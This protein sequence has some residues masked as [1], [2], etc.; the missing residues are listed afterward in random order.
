MDRQQLE[1]FDAAFAE[2]TALL[3][4]DAVMRRSAA[5]VADGAALDVVWIAEP[6]DADRLVVRHL[7][8]TRTAVLEGLVVPRGWGLGGKVFAHG[9]VEAVDRYF[10]SRRITHHFDEQVASEGIE[11]MIAAPIVADG[12]TLAVLWG[13]RRRAGSI[14]SRTGVV[15]E[16]AMRGAAT[17]LVAAE[18]AERLAETAVHEHR[19]ALALGLHDSVG[20]MLFAIQAGIHDLSRGLGPDPALRGQ[21]ERIE[22]YAAEAA[23]ALRDSL[24]ALSVP[25]RQLALSVALRAD[26]RAFEQRSGIPV[27]FVVLATE[28]PAL[29][30]TRTE[31]L[32][33]AARE[34][35]LNVEK[36]A[37]ASSV[38]LALSTGHGRVQVT[39]TDDGA[40]R[41]PPGPAAR[42]G[43][44]LGATSDRLARLGGGLRLESPE[45]GGTIFRAWLP[46]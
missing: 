14:G 18:R 1:A 23:S 3:D 37:R 33:D 16:R 27:S 40:G 15:V 13:G 21:A 17:A 10:G 43:L 46:G 4:H 12:R 8:R 38:A 20:A 5:L 25:P 6:L 11:A 34:A 35:L 30:P 2:L 26:C 22:R 45:E 31:A 29:D 32:V 36:H 39:V 41:P 42:R 7:H 24:Q 44:G 28:L 19:R 9:R